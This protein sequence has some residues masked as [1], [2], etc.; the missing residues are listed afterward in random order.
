MTPRFTVDYKETKEAIFRTCELYR[1]D[2]S[3]IGFRVGASALALMILVV[4]LGRTGIMGQGTKQLLL[5]LLEYWG[6]W[7]LIFIAIEL[8]RRTLGKKLVSTAAYGDADA[9]YERRKEKKLNDLPVKMDFYDDHFVN[10]TQGKQHTF[11]YNQVLKLLESD[12]A[13]GIVVRTNQGI[14]TLFGFPKEALQD[15]SLT[16]FKSFIEGACPGVK[17]GFYRF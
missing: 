11:Y 5:F 17:K 12:K 9:A 14:K 7:L 10:D 4:I 1:L 2:S 6:I 15:T 3:I 16:T 13:I 8:F